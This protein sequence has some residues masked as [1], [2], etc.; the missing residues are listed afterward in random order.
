MQ[1]Q[2]CVKRGEVVC[3]YGE[4]GDRFY[5]VLRGTVGIK[6]PTEISI[7]DCEDYLKVLNV[8]HEHL[9]A[10]IIKIRDPHSRLAKQLLEIIPFD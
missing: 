10:P 6:V 4:I 3:G 9:A 8:V 7:P 5:V 1:L 2:E